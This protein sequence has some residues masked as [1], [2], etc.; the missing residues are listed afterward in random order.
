MFTAFLLPSE[1]KLHNEDRDFFIFTNLFP[2]PGRQTGALIKVCL[3]F[4]NFKR[5]NLDKSLLL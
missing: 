2:K 5:D 3:P 4:M 1:L